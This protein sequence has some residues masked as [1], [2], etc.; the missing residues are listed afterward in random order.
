[1]KEIIK[2]EKVKLENLD[3]I[4]LDIFINSHDTIDISCFGVNSEDK[5]S[6]DRYFVFYNQKSSPNSEIVNSKNG[7]IEI[8]DVKLNLLPSFINKLVFVATLDGAGNFSTIQN[9]Y[10]K[11]SSKNNKLF[12]LVGNGTDEHFNFRFNGSLFE[13]EKAIIISEMYRKDGVWR[14]NSFAQGFNGGLSALLKH[15]GGE[16]KIEDQTSS[17]SSTSTKT[18]LDKKVILE[19]RVEKEAPQLVNLTKSFITSL[20]K[21]QNLKNITVKVA[22]VLDASGSMFG[23]YQRGDV[24]LIVD[25][26][27]PIALYF[28][29]DGEIETWAFSD[30]FKRLTTVTTKNILNYINKTD[31]GYTSWGWFSGNNEPVVMR[32]I[33]ATYRNSKIPVFVIFISDGGVG[34]DS[35]I[36]SLLID[37]SKYPIFWQFV[38]IGGSNYGILQQLDTLTGR[39]VD[40]CN[41]FAL[42]HIKSVSDSQLYDSLLKELPIW[43]NDPKVKKML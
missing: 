16:E 25:K 24:Q 30:T 33:F 23:Q 9:S 40:N 11:L 1:M 3:Q 42:D 4:R 37:Y 20:D 43:L 5:L 14:L 12:G 17:T 6:D 19:K 41:F 18:N 36:K 31:G 2:G 32:D 28:D 7:N 13:K 29:D 35:L 15:F 21:K 39:H 27:M 8:F 26:T 10:F 34:Y 22:L 38:G